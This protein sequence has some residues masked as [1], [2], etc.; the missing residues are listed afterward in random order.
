MTRSASRQILCNDPSLEPT[1]VA[2]FVLVFTLSVFAAWFASG[3]IESPINT[4][5]AASS[6][7]KQREWTGTGT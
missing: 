5:Q 6:L 2:V 1:N 3:A 7:V 4:V